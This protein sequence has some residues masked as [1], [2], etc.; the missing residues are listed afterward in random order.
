MAKKWAQIVAVIALICIIISV[1]STWVL[2]ILWNKNQT[3]T[4]LTPQQLEELQQLINSQSEA[5]STWETIDAW[6]TTNTWEAID[7]ENVEVE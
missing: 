6:E 3:N 2:V 7:E 1:I 4:E 5:V